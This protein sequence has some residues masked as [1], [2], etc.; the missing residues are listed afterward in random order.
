M[1]L[2]KPKRGC[3]GTI[4]QINAFRCFI[5]LSK[6]GSFY[7][8]AQNVHMTQ[9][10]LNKTITSLEAKL[11][12]Q[13]I[14]RSRSG[15]R[16]TSKGEEFLGHAR[17]IVEDYD[18]MLDNLMRS[19]SNAALSEFPAKVS[20]TYYPLQIMAGLQDSVVLSG[21]IVISEVSFNDA[22]ETALSAESDELFIIDLHP[23]SHK[24]LKEHRDLVFETFFT[25]R[26]GLIWSDGNP[27]EG[28]DV[29]HRDMASKMPMALNSQRDMMRLTK[30]VF[31][32]NPLTNITLEATSPRLLLE[33]T[34]RSPE[35]VATFDS[36]GFI[37]SQIDDGMPT[38]GVHFTPFSTPDS[39]CH[40]GALYNKRHQPPIRMLHGIRNLQAR[41]E[42][43][44]PEHF[45][46]HPKLL[47][48]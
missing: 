31:R 14:E 12:M 33:Y 11:G 45:E 19:E 43:M 40:V 28:V 10:G 5:E 38:E 46:N 36:F 25:T 22:I 34:Q 7:A 42:A 15:I 41:I 24:I 35:R 2:R 29:L 4:M 13:L 23:Y 30:W 21:N 16:L 47:K 27:L 48:L 1:R 18:S 3:T 9:Q 8:A 26:F 32:D 44:F 20:A 39:I 6:A 17:R 37:L